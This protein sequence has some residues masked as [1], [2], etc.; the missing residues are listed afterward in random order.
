MDRDVA[1]QLYAACEK[2]LASL[3]EAEQ[4]IHRMSDEDERRRLL[5]ALSSAIAEVLGGVRAPAVL[6]YPDLEPP[7]PLGQPDTLLTEEDEE[8]VSMLGAPD[9]EVIDTAL[10]AE[11]SSSWRKVA[12]VVGTTMRKL[13]HEFPDLPDSYYALRVTELVASGRLESQGNL[14]YM[15]F[16][17]VRLPLTARS[18]A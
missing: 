9:L 17:E 1:K 14:D 4:A 10:L 6:Q 3:N 12:R 7:E 11:C 2:T 13:Q 18:A 8:L 15:R 5:R 16:S